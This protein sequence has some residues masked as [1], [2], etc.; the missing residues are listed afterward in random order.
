LAHDHAVGKTDVFFT[1]RQLI[2][3]Q[4]EI[5]NPSRVFEAEKL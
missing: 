2:A 1:P 3:A 5:V 4:E